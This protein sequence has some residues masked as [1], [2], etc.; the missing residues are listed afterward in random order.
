[1]CGIFGAF[2]VGNINKSHIKK[3]AIQSEQRG[4]DSSGLC[5][6]HDSNFNGT[7]HYFMNESVNNESAPSFSFMRSFSI[8][9]EVTFSRERF[10][11][12]EE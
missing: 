8:K 4:I 12:P 5:Y 1:M 3:L 6:I 7:L 2:T 9:K 11:F 10:A